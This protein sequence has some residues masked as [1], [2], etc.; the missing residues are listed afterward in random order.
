M[1]TGV[2]VPSVYSFKKQNKAKQSRRSPRKRRL[3][4]DTNTNEVRRSPR[5][6]LALETENTRE[7]AKENYNG[8][9]A[10]EI[11][12][13]KIMVPHAIEPSATSC[14]SCGKYL[15]DIQILISKTEMLNSENAELKNINQNLKIINRDISMRITSYEN[16]S[17][18]E[19]KFKSFT[20]LEVCKSHIL[21]DYLDP[22]DNCEEEKVPANHFNLPSLF[23]AVSKP[24]PKSK[25]KAIDQLF[26]ILTWLR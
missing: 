18:D 16:I 15:P 24:G 22:G 5:K 23:N 10:F 13:Q 12:Q 19:D 26:M 3:S 9:V 25:M 7:D 14:E 11:D 17:T 6:K 4:S 20:G 2:E 21:Y 8:N 1:K